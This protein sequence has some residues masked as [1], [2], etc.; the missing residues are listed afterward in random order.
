MKNE[1]KLEMLKL[2]DMLRELSTHGN[3]SSNIKNNK[4][5]LNKVLLFIADK[6]EEIL[7]KE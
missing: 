7:D 6:I 3:R 2:C 4:E 1:K 5:E